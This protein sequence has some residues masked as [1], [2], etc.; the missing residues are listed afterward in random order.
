[1]DNLKWTFPE[2]GLQDA[3]EA[4]DGTLSNFDGKLGS[5]LREAIQNSADARWPAFDNEKKVE[6]RVSVIKLT[7]N[8][9]KKFLENMSWET[10][11]SHLNAV[12]SSNTQT[13][14]S[15]KNKI[16][17][18][19]KNIKNSSL[20]LI[21]IEDFNTSGLYGY[22]MRQDSDNSGV[23]NAFQAALFSTGMSEKNTG[24]S[25]GSY[26]MGKFALMK[27]SSIQTIIYNTCI[28][29]EK[30]SFTPSGK[31]YDLR[32]F[33]D[34][35]GDNRLIGKISI[36]DH[37]IGEKRYDKQG[38]LG[39]S[40]IRESEI[41][42]GN[43]NK[44]TNKETV[45]ISAWP[46]EEFV[47][48]LYLERGK[49][50]GTSVLIVGYDPTEDFDQYERDVED[51]VQ[52]IKRTISVNFW[53]AMAKSDKLD[54]GIDIHVGGFENDKI[55]EDF[56]K[57]DPKD[58][59]PQHVI[60]LKT[61]EEEIQNPKA[62]FNTDGELRDFGDKVARFVE[63]K[64][65]KTK[66]KSEVED[67]YHD[68][69][70]HDIAVLVEYVNKN[71]VIDK[72]LLNKVALFRSPGM[73]VKYDFGE[74][75]RTSDYRKIKN[76]GKNFIAIAIA[77]SYAQDPSLE[78]DAKIAD[79]F[80]KNC[81]LPHHDSWTNKPESFKH[82]Y[83][84]RGP[85]KTLYEGLNKISSVVT[86]LLKEERRV[87]SNIPIE[88]RKD[89]SIPSEGGTTKRG[90]VDPPLRHNFRLSSTSVNFSEKTLNYTI[91]SKLIAPKMLD[92]KV[93]VEIGISESSLQ[94]SKR[95]LPFNIKKSSIKGSGGKLIE[96]NVF[97]ID[98]EKLRQ[99]RSI[100]FEIV[101]NTKEVGIDPFDIGIELDKPIVT[102]DK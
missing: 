15:I 62:N 82:I 53:P 7:G 12:A 67:N 20:Y 65:P 90:V 1:M 101:V 45:A 31:K 22:E 77:G 80:F 54:G 8:H 13:A 3:N 39:N 27:G 99:H 16:K 37:L 41:D 52:E 55:I 92:G 102:E 84:Q 6:V 81:E 47:K 17:K 29:K 21:K 61:F 5:I 48:S 28:S 78:V 18:G 76:Y 89:L 75:N 49:K 42:L 97:E 44:H 9:K 74:N 51:I 24:G 59:V 94:G 88:M 100:Q 87:T 33:T 91:S 25:G 72:S 46:N 98:S 38:W 11:E 64:I 36:G 50:Q 57:V 70:E 26:G 23:K 68:S 95:K 34:N 79:Q 93:K 35:S 66:S 56:N 60:L 85:K 86:Q 63:M 30:G 83:P 69:A 2:R 71:E 10:L 40:E 32:E 58:F 14:M 96:N 43:G 73:V 4:F 19:L